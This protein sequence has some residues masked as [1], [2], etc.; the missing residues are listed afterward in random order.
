MATLREVLVKAEGDY[1]V[2]IG[3]KGGSGFLWCGHIALLQDD[4]SEL[5]T[6]VRDMYKGRIKKAKGHL[7]TLLRDGYSVGRYASTN[8]KKTGEFG[9]AEGYLESIKTYFADL[10]KAEQKLKRAEKNLAELVPMAD[11]EL[12]EAYRSTHEAD[13][14]IVIVSGNETGPAWD[15]EEFMAVK[16]REK[17]ESIGIKDEEDTE[18]AESE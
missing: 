13:T 7:N 5:E 3:T 1:N 14:A 4:M 12:I 10:E 17:R 11:R 6:R 15:L 16:E 8:Y 18:E 9:T 2:K